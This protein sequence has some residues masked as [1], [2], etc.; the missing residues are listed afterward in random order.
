[1]DLECL[2]SAY[3][4]CIISERMNCVVKSVNGTDVHESQ[5]KGRIFFWTIHIRPLL[6]A[7]ISMLMLL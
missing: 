2:S 5:Q 3:V 4:Y 6:N 7:H 1:M